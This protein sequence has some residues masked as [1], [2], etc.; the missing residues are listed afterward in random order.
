ML[1]IMLMIRFMF[2]L[3]LTHTLMIATVLVIVIGDVICKEIMMEISAIIHHTM[4]AS[5][6]VNGFA[7][8]LRAHASSPALSCHTAPLPHASCAAHDG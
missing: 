8:S 7:S 3:V 5:Q 4:L 2:M 6:A 1:V